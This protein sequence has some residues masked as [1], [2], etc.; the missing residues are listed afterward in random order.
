MNQNAIN[1]FH[2][3]IRATRA[4]D[5]AERERVAARVEVAGVITREQPVIIEDPDVPGE[6]WRIE[7]L[8]GMVRIKPE[9]AATIVTPGRPADAP[10]KEP[11]PAAPP[12]IEQRP[13][14]ASDG[15]TDL[16]I[17]VPRT[18]TTTPDAP[19]QKKGG[20]TGSDPREHTKDA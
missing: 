3:F 7:T 9:P 18:S 19:R 16:A 17:D 10:A 6:R 5:Q 13:V 14:K 4:A 20:K 11:K 2:R 1:A 15:D 8:G 12:V